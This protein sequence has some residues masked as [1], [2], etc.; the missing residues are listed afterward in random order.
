MCSERKPNVMKR[1]L[2]LFFAVAL[3][4]SANAQDE[5]MQPDVNCDGYVNV[6]DLLG[7][8]SYFGAEDLDGDGIWDSQDDCV[9]DGCGVCDGPGPQVMLVDT[10]ILTVDSIFIDAINEWYVYEVPDTTFI[11]VC[12][13]PGCTD[14]EA[15]NY[16]PEAT[17]DDGS[18]VEPLNPCSGL[19]SIYF[20]GHTYDLVAIGNQ[21]WFAE[22]L[23][24]DHYANGEAI[25]GELSDED[26]T[27][28]STGAQAIYNNDDSFLST[29]GRLYNWLAVDDSRGLCP[30]GWHVPTNDEFTEL[31]DF[32]GGYSV[33]GNAMKSSPS[34]VPNWDGSNTSGFSA[35]AGGR[36]IAP[37]LGQPAFFGG[38]GNDGWFW[39]SSGGMHP[40][41]RKLESGS[42]SVFDS[43]LPLQAEGMSVRC[44]RDSDATDVNEVSGCTDASASNYN[45]SAVI[46]DGSCVYGPADPCENSSTITFDGYTYELVAIGDQCWFAENLRTEH[47]ANGDAIPGELSDSDWYET[48]TGAQAIYNNDDS[49]LSTH[50][51]L[52]NWYA[53]D[54]SRGLCPSGWHVPT[55]AEF[56]TLEMALGMSE[57]EANSTGWRGTDQGAQMKS[58][59]SDDPFWD[60]TN[61]SGYSAMTGGFRY[62]EGWYYGGTIDEGQTFFWTSTP[63]GIGAYY[64]GLVGGVS[65]IARF[66]LDNDPRDGVSIRCVRDE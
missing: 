19:I 18:C 27:V 5:C 8:L 32:L 22:N 31:T 37:L 15:E 62:Y 66:D 4:L 23:R 7:L 61:T 11:F 41:N 17:E 28:I 52:Y 6:N 30:S 43:H 64:R 60:G 34:D 55:D 48:S 25:P 13:N 54:D 59:P 56:M 20:D 33:A 12:E 53:V 10:I 16:D 3:W 42:N 45:P 35:L 40:S 46:E 57:S 47:Y 49:F 21:C 26:W 24:S 65:E 58:S 51:R 50:G 63:I 44:V 2:F 9:D 36:R 38:Q 1:I 14:P 29:H 39:S